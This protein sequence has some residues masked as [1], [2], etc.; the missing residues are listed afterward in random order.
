[1][2][3]A[4][5]TA[6]LAAGRTSAVDL[7]ERALAKI[8]AGNPDLGAVWYLAEAEARMAARVSDAR[9]T[10]GA[11]LS[12]LD[13]VPVGLK[14]NIDVAGWPVTNGLG[15]SWVAET[16]AWITARLRALGAIPIAKL[17][18]HEAALGATSDNPHHGAVHNP[19][20]HGF[21]PGG[22]SGGSAAAVTAGWLALT[23]GTDTMGSVRLPAAYCGCVG[24]K[25]ARDVLP[26]DGVFP[27]APSLDHL[28][29]LTAS[30]ADTAL[31]MR[32]IT[33][34]EGRSLGRPLRLA[35]PKAMA[36]VAVDEEVSAAFDS[37]VSRLRAV[38]EIE[39]IDLGINLAELRKAGLLIVV[40][41][42]AEALSA[43]RARRPDALSSELTGFLDYG[44]KAPPDKVAAR[45]AVLDAAG[46]VLADVLTKCDGVLLP[47][48]PQVSFPFTQDAPANQADLTA[49]ANA[50]G[51]AAIS[52]P[53]RVGEGA[54][55][56]GLQIVGDVPFA[57]L[58][59]LEKALG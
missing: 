23:F 2:R 4:T 49:L 15:A 1:M 55:P 13:G 39:Q 54:L 45:R 25:P 36:G 41:E 31:A 10:A 30:V 12:E 44:L 59:E 33:G 18:M 52:L 35:V 27:L 53:F 24:F 9:R 48:A 26:L 43:I 56:V 17:A 7:V 29:P 38:V 19:I 46:P 32:L 51:T 22:S 58:A 47:T 37:A 16:D 42:G 21:T 34:V 14:D 11:P 6:D 28:G 8:A 5:V 40:A 50:T 57:A 3:L 20:R